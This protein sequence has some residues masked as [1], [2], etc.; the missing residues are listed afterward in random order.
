MALGDSDQDG[1]TS[2]A[3]RISV[4][5]RNDSYFLLGK[6][7]F[8]FGESRRFTGRINNIALRQSGPFFALSPREKA[9]FALSRRYEGSNKT[10]KVTD[11]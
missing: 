7:L 10:S 8:P 1:K 5:S 2:C 4:A 11:F 3:K 6:A 9:K